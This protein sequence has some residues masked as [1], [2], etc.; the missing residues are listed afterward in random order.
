MGASRNTPIW[1]AFPSD[2][3]FPKTH[4]THHHAANCSQAA[5]LAI[6]KPAAV[7]LPAAKIRVTA[8]AEIISALQHSGAEFSSTLSSQLDHHQGF[9]WL[10]PVDIKNKTRHG[11]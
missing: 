9:K 3:C 1:E 5:V 6:H 10:G 11:D 4:S 2:L 8:F 7:H